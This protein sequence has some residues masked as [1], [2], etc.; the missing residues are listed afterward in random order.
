ML[1]RHPADPRSETAARCEH[2]P[3]SHLGHQCGGDNRTN[4]RDFLQP[5]ALF[6]R[7]VP[8]MDAFLD[9]HDLCPD[10]R[11]LASKDVEAEPSRR[12]NA[13]SC[14]LAMI[15]SSSAVPLRPFAEIMPSSATCPRIAFDSIVR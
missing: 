10:N 3:I 15:L 1:S 4:A 11:I 12:W 2:L 7:A 8:S 6:T 14:S 13:S 5:P 9:G